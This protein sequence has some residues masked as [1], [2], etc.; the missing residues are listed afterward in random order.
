L[1]KKHGDKYC[2][3]EY[4]TMS[5]SA[6]FLCNNCT[7]EWNARA[8][9]VINGG[10]GCP[11]CRNKTK[12]NEVEKMLIDRHNG[13]IVIKEYCGN[14]NDPSTFECVICGW[15]WSVPCKNVTTVGTG[16]PNCFNIRRGSS[17]VVPFDAALERLFEMHGDNITMLEYGGGLVNIAKFLCNIC[18]TSWSVKASDVISQ[19]HSCPTCKQSKGETKIRKYLKKI[20]V[21][22]KPEFYFS[23][24]V[25]K[26]MLPF[27]FYVPRYNL[28]IEYQGIQHHEP[29]AFFGGENSLADVQ[30]RDKIKLDY[31]NTNNIPFLRINFWDFDNIEEILEKHIKEIYNEK[32]AY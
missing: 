22:F 31:C 24:C 6:L 1:F 2:L 4:K 30:K 3:L 26:R 5:K 32:H 27:D 19:G 25:H 14:M 28:C 11:V 21:E 16:C 20:N 12:I 15:S 7:N 8:G 18:G 29:I 17:L 23:D 10:S 9:S 13:K